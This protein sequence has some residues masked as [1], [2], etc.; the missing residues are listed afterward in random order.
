MKKN[1]LLL[2]I[3]VALYSYLFYDQ[4]SGINFLL[5]TTCL[6]VFQ[7]IKDQLLIL[8]KAWIFSA[9]ASLASAIAILIY[10]NSLSAITNVLSLSLAASFSMNKNSSLILALLYS[11]FSYLSSIAFM[12][13]AFFDKKIKET[14][15]KNPMGTK[16]F[17]ILIPILI[18]AIFFFLYREANPIFKDFTKNINF[19]FITWAWVRFTLLGFILTYAFFNHKR[20]AYLFNKDLEASDQLNKE[21]LPQQSTLMGKELSKENENLSGIVL[22]VLLNLLLFV[23]NF[24]DIN[25]L[26]V[27]RALPAGMTYAEFVHQGVGLL[28]VSILVAIAII[29]FYFRGGLNFYE[30]NRA[31]KV[32]AFLWIIQNAVLIIT[33][34][35]KNQ[36]YVSEYS[37]TYKRIGVFVYLL[38]S[39]IGLATTFIKILQTKSNWF[40]FRKN[41][42]AFYTILILSCFI[43][44]D[45]LI[46]KFNIEHSKELDKPYLLT[47]SASTLPDLINI[48]DKKDTTTIEEQ[49][50]FKNSLHSKSFG[51][52]NYWKNAQWQSW[53]IEDSYVY[54]EIVNLEKKGK[55]KDLDL[56]NAGITDLGSISEFTNIESLELSQ[57][58]FQKLEQLAS[59]P[60]L[61]NLNLVQNNIDSLHRFPELAK[62]TELNISHNKIEDLHYLAKCASLETLLFSGNQV[63]YDKPFPSL[64]NLKLLD[65]SSTRIGNLKIGMYGNLKELRLNNLGRQ[66]IPT[67]PVLPKLERLELSGNQLTASDAV[68]YTSISQLKELKEISLSQ[69]LINSLVPIAFGGNKIENLNIANNEL[70]NAWGIELF[71]QLKSLSMSTCGLTDAS[72]LKT[73]VTLSYLDLSGNRITNLSPLVT[74]SNLKVLDLSANRVNDLRPLA[75]LTGLEELHLAGNDISDIN[76][77]IALTHLKKLSLENNRISDYSSLVKLKKLEFLEVG[78]VSDE[79]I[80][81]I[82]QVKSLRIF[83]CANLS[84]TQMKELKKAIPALQIEA[85][86]G[87]YRNDYSEP[88]VDTYPMPADN[89]SY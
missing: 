26:W 41:A 84:E 40:L 9:L 88:A 53:N 57:N 31:L 71:T 17:L 14:S 45:L 39:L 28:I 73:S 37:L 54:Q 48:S 69:N 5:F 43:N 79:M 11:I 61:S 2:V 80:K 33:I 87:A 6:L 72:P 67:I 10:G 24:L 22:F 59:F 21:N 44:W 30:K 15:A 77:L 70:K 34:A 58:N 13:T 49:N 7:L 56:H 76:P 8:N 23:V 16:F 63:Q 47:L 3:T 35:S 29:L 27:M 74:L 55:L 62:L 68:L 52:M 66:N 38:L 65:L 18:T 51:F 82:I 75:Y 78:N 36:L 86:Y 64:P 1:D 32:L 85:R 46:T 83:K 19:D 60:N 4:S 25:S 42:W 81:T 50:Q 12:V 20:I 89:S